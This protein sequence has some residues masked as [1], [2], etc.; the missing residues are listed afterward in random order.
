MNVRTVARAA[1]VFLGAPALLTASWI[2]A[3]PR[4]FYDDFP[5]VGNPWVSPDG[6]FNEHLLRDY[7]AATLG[8]V[9]LT[10]C[11][12]VWFNRPLVVATGLAWLAASIPHVAY[13]ALNTDPYGSGDAVAIVVSLTLVPLLALAAVFAGLRLDAKPLTTA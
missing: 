13:H 10:V 11:A 1:L 8:L 9:V 12:L 2:L 3:A 5:G 4:S 7:G 6:P